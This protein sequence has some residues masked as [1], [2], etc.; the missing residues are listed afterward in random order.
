MHI[1][2]R[3]TRGGELIR[4][5]WKAKANLDAPDEVDC[6]SRIAIYIFPSRIQSAC[7]LRGG[8]FLAYQCFAA[9]MDRIEN[10]LANRCTIGSALACCDVAPIMDP[11]RGYLQFRSLV[12]RD[13]S[14]MTSRLSRQTKKRPLHL[15]AADG[16]TE[17]I[18]ALLQSKADLEI[19]DQV[20]LTNLRSGAT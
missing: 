3:H 13:I 1:A 2:I 9:L 18:R 7:R 15:A 12:L 20:G 16:R 10:L 5:L 14:L 8:I 11:G 17:A 6:D 19:R 4:A